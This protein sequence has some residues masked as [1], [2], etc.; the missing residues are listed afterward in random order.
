MSAL[1]TEFLSAP[2]VLTDVSSIKIGRTRMTDENDIHIDGD[3]VAMHIND[4]ENNQ[5]NKY[6]RKYTNGKMPWYPAHMKGV[7]TEKLYT[8]FKYGVARHDED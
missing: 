5:N 2:T 3:S 6:Y 4:N 1:D 7:S 8:L